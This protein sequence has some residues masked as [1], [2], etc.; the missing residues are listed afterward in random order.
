MLESYSSTRF[1]FLFVCLFQSNINFFWQKYLFED[2][3]KRDQVI[4]NHL[5]MMQKRHEEY[6]AKKK[7]PE[8]PVQPQDLVSEWKKTP[9][10]PVESIQNS[11]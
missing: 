5:A 6:I 1:T 2:P 4:D 11:T 7:M 8:N 3:V 10:N 9:V